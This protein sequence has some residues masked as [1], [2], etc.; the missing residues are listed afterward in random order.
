MIGLED[1]QVLAQ[2][3][4]IAHGAGAR[5]RLACEIVGIDERTLQHWKARQGLVAG[6]GRPVAL[7]PTPSHAL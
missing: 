4:H 6:D 1:C 2:D 7:R 3:I 5:L